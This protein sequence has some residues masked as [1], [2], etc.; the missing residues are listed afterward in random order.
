MEVLLDVAELLNLR[1]YARTYDARLKRKHWNRWIQMS[2]DLNSQHWFYLR[3]AHGHEY[4]QNLKRHVATCTVQLHWAVDDSRVIL[5]VAAASWYVCE[6]DAQALC[7]AAHAMECPEELSKSEGSFQTEIFLKLA[8]VG[9]PIWSWV[10]SFQAYQVPWWPLTPCR[11]RARWFD[12]SARHR[13]FQALPKNMKKNME[14]NMKNAKLR[15]QKNRKLRL[16]E[17]YAF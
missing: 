15:M 6:L 14:M 11:Q 17:F 10:R 16:Q 13:H 9:F 1:V 2:K 12:A 7:H 4:Y 5:W 8:E 3:S